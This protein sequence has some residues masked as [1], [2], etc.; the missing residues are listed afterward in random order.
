[1]RRISLLVALTLLLACSSSSDETKSDSVTPT[2]IVAADNTPEAT[3]TPEV[4]VE[5]VPEV[6]EVLPP[7]GPESRGWKLKRGVVHLHSALS[8]DGCAPDGYEDNGGPDPVCLGQLRAAPCANDMDFLMMTDHPGY[9]EDH[10]FEEM[11]QYNEGEGDQIIKDEQDRP[12]VNLMTCPADSIVD[13]VYIF[14]G[15]EGSKHMP[16]AMAG[17]IPPKVFQQNYEDDSPLEEA[18]IARDLTHEHGG[19]VYIPHPEEKTISVER[20]VAVPLDGIEIYN[21]HAN[22]MTVLESLDTIFG[23]DA[24]LEGAENPPDSDLIM[25]FFLA[26]VDKDVEKFDGAAAQI[27][28][29]HIAATDI[30][31][32]VEIP[33][34]CPDGI[35]GSL[36]E[37]IAEDYP[38]F[39]A[40]AMNGG[41]IPMADGERVD[42]YG[43]SFR[44]L[45][46]RALVADDDPQSIREAIGMGRSFSCF[47]MFG[48][49]A[50]FDFYLDG[51]D[52]TVEMGEETTF[53]AGLTLHFNTPLLTAAP[54]RTEADWDY[55]EAELTCKLIRADGDGSTVVM[56][57]TGQGGQV[58]V[59]ADVPGAYR[60]F[61]EIIPHHVAADMPGFENL[62]KAV[63]PY[64]YSNAVFVR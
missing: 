23:M 27:R 47:D 59:S 20:I 11:L 58:N 29:S 12:F 45:S 51:G 64:I 35:E 24:F 31:Q 22:L 39:A 13:E 41:P 49:P 50:G 16:L 46:N 15:T 30:H 42:S 38:N 36:C 28:L 34:L 52:A 17:P 4:K 40:F 9:S 7:P 63:Y 8:H 18:Q 3:T 6:T 60:V 25:L 61:C 53:A 10:T 55:T 56:E 14:A 43:R 54:W 26:A 2:E 5:V 44:W 62:T 32:N 1:M 21:I 19:Y 37:P 57:A 48:Y 33:A